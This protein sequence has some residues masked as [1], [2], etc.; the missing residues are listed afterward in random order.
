MHLANFWQEMGIKKGAGERH[1]VATANGNIRVWARESDAQEFGQ[2]ARWV[3]RGASE[4]D[5][6]Q[7]KNQKEHRR[8]DFQLKNQESGSEGVAQTWLYKILAIL[9]M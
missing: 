6:R 4:L 2:E 7:S 8:P 3:G 9:F 1:R 5:D